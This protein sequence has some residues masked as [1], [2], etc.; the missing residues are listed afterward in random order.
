MKKAR[1]RLVLNILIGFIF[2]GV[3]LTFYSTFS[4]DNEYSFS[5]VVYDIDGGYIKD[6][7]VN[8]SVELFVKY[9]ELD[10]CTIKVL[11]KYN[12]EI[13]SGLIPNGSRTVVNDV[14]GNAVTSYVN[15]VKGDIKSNGIID[16][17]D[18]YDMGKCLIRDC[19][20]EEYEAMSVD[21]ND[22]GKLDISDLVLLDRAVT[23]GY[24]GLSVV[25]SEIVLQ[26]KEVGRVVAN[27]SPSYGVN[28]NV[29][30]SSSDESIV[31]VDEA[32]RVTGKKE[33]NAI[34]KVT[35]LDGK[36][37]TEASIK[38]D[39]T[40][41]LASYEGTGYIG[42]NNI[43]VDIKAID[44]TGITCSVANSKIADCEIVD[45]TLVLK[46]K[47]EGKTKVA[48]SSPNYGEVTYDL[49][50]YSVYFNI[51]PQYICSTPGNAKFIT[52]SGFNTG[53][54]SFEAE[55][56]EIIKSAYMEMYGNRNMLRINMGA[57]Q[58]RTTLKATESNG[59][60]AVL[61]IVDVT[62]IRLSD[63]GK[64]TKVGEEVSVDVISD[65]IGTLTCKSNNEET[66]TCRIEDNKLIVT[67]L[68]KGAVTVDVYNNMSYNDYTYECGQ[69]QF[70]T[71]IQE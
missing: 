60:S 29:K 52:V 4:L 47:M 61:V 3:V 36:Y 1:R 42:G 14:N 48:V 8:T 56:S 10:N 62:S 41:Q 43:I 24:T 15:I 26:S 65:N 5:S 63:I 18:F 50:V 45:E 38:V 35:T 6:I 59:N 2:M 30:W 39:N 58:G 32:G 22:D 68:K 64:V 12:E 70:I 27:V 25:D 55:D 69:V 19:S 23:L 51:M 57:K 16:M 9:F 53:T 13:V 54:L 49:A 67:P 34:I 46:P 7:S 31:T 17:N 20:F 21:I 37:S 28:Q 71:V 44:Y 66:G 33:G 11:D 40:I